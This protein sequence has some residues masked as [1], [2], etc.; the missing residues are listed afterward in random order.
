MVNPVHLLGWASSVLLVVTLARQVYRQW[1]SGT[2]KGVSSW[3]FAGQL[4]ASSGFFIYSLLIDSV[5]FAVTNALLM[6]N[7]TC[8]WAVLIRHR[9]RESAQLQVQAKPTP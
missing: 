2:S 4:A 9:R 3:L 5:V 1:A 6:I 7:A 8:G